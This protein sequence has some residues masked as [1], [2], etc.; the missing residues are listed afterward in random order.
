MNKKL[1]ELGLVLFD[2]SQNDLRA[3]PKTVRLQVLVVLSLMWS[4]IFTV[5]FFSYSYWGLVWSVSVVAHI[6]AIIG[7]Y[8]TLKSFVLAKNFKVRTDGYHS[9][10][11]SRQNLWINGQ[12]VVLPKGDPGGEHE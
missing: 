9:S 7:G 4:T 3:L 2:D 8:F 12:K 5:I 11:R 6:L 10:S 1:Y